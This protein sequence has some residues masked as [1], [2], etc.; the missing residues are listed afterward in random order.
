MEKRISIYG[1]GMESPDRESSTGIV[2]SRFGGLGG[3]WNWQS[4]FCLTYEVSKREHSGRN[5]EKNSARKK[6]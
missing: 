3:N 6:K 2:L 4:R 1:T 5:R